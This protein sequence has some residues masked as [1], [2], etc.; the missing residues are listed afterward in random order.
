MDQMELPLEWEADKMPT[1][2][3]EEMAPPLHM[4]PLGTGDLSFLAIWG[5]L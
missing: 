2:S 3:P 1:L 5:G 4:M